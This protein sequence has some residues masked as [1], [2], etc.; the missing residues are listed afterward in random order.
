MTP[1]QDR[2]DDV[3]A[4]A[5]PR[6]AQCRDVEARFDSRAQAC[7]EAWTERRALQTVLR[8]LD[9]EEMPR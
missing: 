5:R 1:L 3:R 8:M 7:V 2:V 6:I 9:G 4:W